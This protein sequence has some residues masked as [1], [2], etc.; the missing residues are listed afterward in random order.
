MSFDIGSGR[1][2][3]NDKDQFATVGTNPHTESRAQVRRAIAVTSE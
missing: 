1:W 2:I 3:E